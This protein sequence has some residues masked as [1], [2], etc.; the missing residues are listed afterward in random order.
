MTRSKECFKC[1]IVKPLDEFYKHKMMADGHVNKCK[2]CNKKDVAKHRLENLE[3]IREYDRKRSKLKHRVEQRKEITKKWIE[4]FPEKRFAQKKLGYAIK[5]GKIKKQPCWVCGETAE[6]HHPDYSRP[7][8]VVWLCTA[9]HR[10]TH[11][12]IKKEQI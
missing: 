11:A 4:D 2:E 1:K 9:H 12:L 10:Q 3:R 5:S 8:D 6:A 7:L